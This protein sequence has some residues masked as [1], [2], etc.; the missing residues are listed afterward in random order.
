MVY[1]ASPNRFSYAPLGPPRYAPSELDKI[2]KLSAIDFY[3][4][5][6]DE[7]MLSVISRHLSEQEINLLRTHMNKENF[8]GFTD[9]NT[10]SL[11]EVKRLTQNA[12][13]C[14]IL[15]VDH[16]RIENKQL[17]GLK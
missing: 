12:Q 1:F 5:V 11:E 3:P 9:L 6:E 4:I 10:L 14:E 7:A 17:P 2:S 8:K 15:N 16:P 13:E